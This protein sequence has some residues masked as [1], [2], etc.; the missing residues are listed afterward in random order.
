MIT[1]KTPP[2]LTAIIRFF[3]A[4]LLLSVLFAG[5]AQA[6]SP[7]YSLE[8][9]EIKAVTG[10]E[11]SALGARVHKIENLE[12]GVEISL[13]IPKQHAS[14]SENGVLEEIV[15]LG[16]PPQKGLPRPKLPQIKRY[17]LINDLEEGRSGLVLY[18]G[19]NEDFV[20]KLNYSD[21]KNQDF[22]NLLEP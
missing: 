13:S 1:V 8:T 3:S 18:L 12:N 15:V 10:H 2:P 9:E 20:L 5:L 19:K 22:Q 14:D 7:I 16:K 6:E 21:D 17:K 4:L 11:E